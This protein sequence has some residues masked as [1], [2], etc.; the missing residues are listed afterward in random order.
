MR[1][2]RG[3]L[4]RRTAGCERGIVRPAVS[5]VAACCAAACLTRVA[6]ELLFCHAR[7]LTMEDALLPA[8]G[9]REPAGELE[10]ELR[11]DLLMLPAGVGGA[12]VT[13]PSVC[14]VGGGGSGSFHRSS[15]STTA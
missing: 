3:A 7:L 15:H 4:A 2:I 8:P 14:A 12:G 9:G 10:R 5:A 6:L 13:A 11:G 1:G